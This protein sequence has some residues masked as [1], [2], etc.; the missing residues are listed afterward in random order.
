MR[1]HDLRA[2]RSLIALGFEDRSKRKKWRGLAD[3]AADGGTGR[4]E[5]ACNPAL[6]ALFVISAAF[7]P[8]STYRQCGP[9]ER[10]R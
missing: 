8:R 2:H 3:G 5:A 10:A 4:R 1:S 6:A 9:D 7:A